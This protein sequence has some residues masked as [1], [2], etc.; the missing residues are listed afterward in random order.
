MKA[1]LEFNLPEETD[2]FKMY[3]KALDAHL[4]IEEFRN[5]LRGLHKHG[6]EGKTISDVYDAFLEMK[7]SYEL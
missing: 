5:Y 6:Y 3:S 4:F 1:I 7:N 2:D